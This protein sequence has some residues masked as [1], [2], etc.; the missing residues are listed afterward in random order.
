M[1]FILLI[2]IKKA[3]LPIPVGIAG[4]GGFHYLASQG[5]QETQ[6]WVGRWHNGGPD[7]VFPIIRPSLP[8]CSL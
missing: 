2:G 5:V 3:Q 8:L 4:F 1:T 6:F 7:A